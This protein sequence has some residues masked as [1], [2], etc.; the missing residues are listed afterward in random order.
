MSGDA[1]DLVVGC[2][3]GGTSTRAVV[4]DAALAVLGRGVAGGGNPIS[5]AGTAAAAFAAALRAALAG[6]DPAR[7]GA[8]VVGVAGGGS[9][10]RD[11]RV[12]RAF[13]DAW[14][15]AGLDCDPDFRSDLEVAY[16]AAAPG[17]DG[18]VLIAGT[19][20]AAAPITGWRAGTTADGLGWLFG[21]RGAGFWIG[22]ESVRA[23]VIEPGPAWGPLAR[24][25]AGAL[26]VVAGGDRRD[27]LHAAYEEEP[28]ALARLAPLALAAADAGDPVAAAVLD[29]AAA[30]LAATLRAVFF[31]HAFFRTLPTSVAEAAIMDGASHTQV[32]FKI[33]LPM[34]KPGLLSILIFNVLGQWNQF[35]LPAF[36]SPEKPVLAQGI[37]TLL[38]QQ[39]YEGNW[40]TLFAALA[41]AMVPVIVVYLVFYR[42]I[43]AGLTSSTLK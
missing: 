25:L 22:R 1:R 5:R 20:A 21:D 6:I 27:L 35:V 16:A 37:A 28:V 11:P 29:E 36:L 4:A 41:I 43:Q 34:A 23:A 38:A 42:Q 8:G 30:H 9:L 10:A 12:R 2:D 19:G 24:S 13:L 18:A 33:M 31:M 14:R 3:L 7:V 40:G 15:S 32:F 17:P 26:G 39:R